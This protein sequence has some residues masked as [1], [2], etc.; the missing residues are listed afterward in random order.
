MNIIEVDGEKFAGSGIDIF[1]AEFM[2]IR[3]SRGFLACSYVN[4]E[5]ADRLGHAAAVVSGVKNFDDMLAAKVRRVSQAAHFF[6]LR[7]FF[8]GMGLLP[9]RIV[10]QGFLEGGCKGRKLACGEGGGF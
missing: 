10:R 8:R 4:I 7:G 6:R 9:F 3:G 2:V 5:T 1:G